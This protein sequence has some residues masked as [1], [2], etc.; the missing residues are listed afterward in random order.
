MAAPG[1]LNQRTPDIV[2]LTM[3][4]EQMPEAVGALI[5]I[6]HGKVG[7]YSTVIGG[8]SPPD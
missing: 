6:A 1:E 4:D 3:P 8:S 2:G 5:Q 7:R